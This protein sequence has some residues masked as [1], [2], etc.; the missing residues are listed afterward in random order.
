VQTVNADLAPVRPQV[1]RCRLRA[2]PCFPGEALVQR[3]S[4][5]E[6]HPSEG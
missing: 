5:S 6:G 4:P 3:L 2:E 1:V